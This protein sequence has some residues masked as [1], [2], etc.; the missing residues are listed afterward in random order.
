[1]DFD[2]KHIDDVGKT[3]L[4]KCKMAIAATLNLEKRVWYKQVYF[5]GKFSSKHADYCTELY[6]NHVNQ[7]VDI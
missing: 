2:F 7:L 1:L 6:L 5:A 4:V 3:Y